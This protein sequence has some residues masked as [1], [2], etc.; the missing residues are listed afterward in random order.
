MAAWTN[1]KSLLSVCLPVHSKLQY[2][3]SDLYQNSKVNL[4][5]AKAKQSEIAYVLVN[6][7]EG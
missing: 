6:D 7:F 3:L 5:L 1:D 4:A 2:Y